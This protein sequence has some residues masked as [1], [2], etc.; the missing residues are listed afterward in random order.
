MATS[1]SSMMMMLSNEERSAMRDIQQLG[2]YQDLECALFRG[3]TTRFWS[4]EGY[5]V[6]NCVHAWHAYKDKRGLSLLRKA[7]KEEK[8]ATK[9]QGFFDAAKFMA[10]AEAA[11]NAKKSR[12]IASSLDGEKE[13]LWQRYLT[14]LAHPDSNLCV[15]D[16]DIFSA[17]A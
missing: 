14:M 5:F 12:I 6:N 17:T 11:H 3:F 13:E 7:E 2:A 9:P 10:R 4:R 1:S 8:E 15:R 16:I